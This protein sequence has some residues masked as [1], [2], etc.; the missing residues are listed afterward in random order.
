MSQ[1]MRRQEE[2][3]IESLKRIEEDIDWQER[4]SY[5]FGVF[6]VVACIFATII[7]STL[8]LLK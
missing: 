4:N 5:R 6:M 2:F 3:T 7:G 8:L 1:E